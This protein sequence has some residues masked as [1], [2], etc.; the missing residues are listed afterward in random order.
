MF[1]ACPKCQQRYKLTQRLAG[2]LTR[3]VTGFYVAAFGAEDRASDFCKRVWKVNQRLDGCAFRRRNIG[4]MQIR[5]LRAW[6][7]S[8]IAFDRSQER[9]LLCHGFR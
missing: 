6:S 9:A 8:T 3:E 1:F 7:T 4:Q 5:R 2:M